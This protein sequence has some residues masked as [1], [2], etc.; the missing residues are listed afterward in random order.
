MADQQQLFI[1]IA[2]ASWETQVKRADKIF[3]DFSDTQLSADVSPGKNSGVYLLG[4]LTAVHDKILPLFGLGDGLYPFLENAFIKNP[5]K[6]GIE[7]PSVKELRQYWNNVNNKLAEHFSKMQADEWFQKHA[8]VSAEDFIKEPHRN[9]LSVL[10][11]RANHL[12]YHMGQV[13][14]L[15]GNNKE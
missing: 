15:S 7:M 11:N 1:K 10:L 5:D 8:S 12:S 14:L 13:I 3:S 6:S 2:V 9:K 4:H